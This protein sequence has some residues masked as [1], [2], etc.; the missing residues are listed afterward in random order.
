MRDL[1]SG[2]MSKATKYAD[3]D[4]YRRKVCIAL[5]ITCGDCHVQYVSTR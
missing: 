1:A 5:D 4:R 3:A 2:I